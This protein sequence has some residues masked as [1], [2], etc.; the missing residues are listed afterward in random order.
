M[1]EKPDSVEQKIILTTIECI[2]KY[3]ISGATNRQI[4]Q[5]AGVNIAAINYYFRSKEILIQRCMEITLKNAFDL[6]DF[7]SM[8]GIP[9]QERCITVLMELI[10]GGF[11]YPGISRAHFHNLL[12]EGQQDPLLAGHLNR[13][14]D[15]FAIDLHERGCALELN[16]LKLGLVQ[17]MSAVILAILASAL[18]EGQP[19]LDLHNTETCRAYITRLVSKLLG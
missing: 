17:I 15:E 12:A 9:A 18:F 5:M 14:I 13:F 16:E 10:Q 8:P 19:G 7:P 11:R 2:E 1:N 6:S 4:A 3:G